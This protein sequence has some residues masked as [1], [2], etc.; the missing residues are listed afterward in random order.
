MR[1][2]DPF[3]VET[4]RDPLERHPTRVHL[5]DPYDH[6]S[7]VGRDDANP[8]RV[9]GLRRIRLRHG[10]E[11]VGLPTRREPGKRTPLETPMG[12]GPNH[13]KEAI[14][15]ERHRPESHA[16]ALRVR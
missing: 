12:L 6:R 8:P 11:A 5:E 7:L 9:L 3:V 4:R 10:R 16:R 14:A 2:P 15:D 1:S 13:L